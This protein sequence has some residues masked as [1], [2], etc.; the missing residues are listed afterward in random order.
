MAEP[1]TPDLLPM[2][3]GDL[4]DEAFDL[5]KRNFALFAGITAV[6][7]VP[8]QIGLNALMMTSEMGRVLSSGAATGT[9]SGDAMKAVGYVATL[10]ALASAYLLVVVVQTAA[11]SAAISDRVLCRPATLWSSYRTA[12][13]LSLPL[14]GTAIIVAVLVGCLAIGAMVSLVIPSAA[15]VAGA[16]EGQGADTTAAVV[17]AVAML[18]AMFMSTLPVTAFGAF[19][20]Q[21]VVVE[22][23]YALRAI[24]RNWQLV[25]G[26]LLLIWLSLVLL[27][28]VIGVVTLAIAAASTFGVVALVGPVLRISGFWEEVIANALSGTV[29][30]L[31]QP[32]LTIYL[33]LL[34]YD[35][36][37]RQEAFDIT[38]LDQQLR[39]ARS[40]VAAS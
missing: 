37:V 31:A 22:R 29:S 36:R 7:Q 17:V 11:L 33:T 35:R 39:A 25:R 34:Y 8:A 4:I 40:Q 9:V 16:S 14:L 13:R 18:V 1:S 20:I 23:L 27:A 2:T 12:L 10:T 5:Y 15:L 32:L 26:G 6:V 24:S 21:I 28:V 3:T 30:L 38:V 19:T